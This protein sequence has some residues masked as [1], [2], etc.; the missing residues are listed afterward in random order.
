MA[1]VA[2]SMVAVMAM[3]ALSIDVITLYLANAEAQ[4]S[5][6]AAALAGARILSLNGITGDPLDSSGDWSAACTLATQVATAVANQNLVA[7]TAPST[8]TV[9]FPDDPSG[10]CNDVGAATKFGVNPIVQVAVQ[11]TA[12]PTFFSRIWGRR[13]ANISGT[14][15]AEAFNPSYS[16]SYTA[17][18]VGVQPRCVKPWIVGNGNPGPPPPPVDYVDPTTGAI[19]NSGGIDIGGAGGF[20]IGSQI[21][22]KPAAQCGVGGCFAVQTKSVAQGQYIAAS[23]QGTP[24]AV[25]TGATGDIWQEAIGGCDQTTVYA[26]GTVGGATAD[27]TVNLGGGVNSDTYTAAEALTNGPAGADQLNPATYP[28]QI[29]AG[30]NNPMVVNGVV[31]DNDVITSSNSI[32][33]VPLMDYTPVAAVAQPP[34]TIVGFLQIFIQNLGNGPGTYGWINGYVLNVSG[35][36]NGSPPTSV[37]GSSPVPV[38]LIQQYP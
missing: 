4:R 19:S 6:D 11:R 27:L 13:S 15:F 5:A 8:I 32:V 7:G 36:G 21:T 10:N 18:I 1:L 12:L 16:A 23:V 26:C 3:A 14:S 34:V 25:A 22:L 20:V 29:E 24:V 30:L 28:F 37:A 2:L 33:T 17:A 31:N 38:R 9:T 35:C